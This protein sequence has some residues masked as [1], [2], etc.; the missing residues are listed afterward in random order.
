MGAQAGYES[1]PLQVGSRS[2]P[3]ANPLIR[4]P[5]HR[6]LA[7]CPLKYHQ[8]TLPLGASGADLDVEDCFLAAVFVE[9]LHYAVLSFKTTRTDPFPPG[10]PQT[11]NSHSP[12]SHPLPRPPFA[13]PPP[14]SGPIPASPSP[15][16]LSPQRGYAAPLHRAAVILLLFFFVR[17]HS[18]TL[19]SLIVLGRYFELA[20]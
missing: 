12:R 11:W 20:A 7:P 5:Y 3:S 1:F 19:S 4:Y 10:A 9:L 18:S 16:H 15:R 8:G 6:L 14:P 2:L 17:G 13:L